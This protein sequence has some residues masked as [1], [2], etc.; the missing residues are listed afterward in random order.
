MERALGRGLFDEFAEQIANPLGM[1]DF[2]PQRQRYARQPYSEQHSTYSFRISTRD[3]A[4]FG[5]LYLSAGDWRGRRLLPAGWVAGSTAVQTITSEG[6]GYGY[7]WWVAHH[8]QLFAG[9]TMP[10]GAFAAYGMSGQFLIVIPELE[11]VV[12]LLADPKRQ[13]QTPKHAA[14]HRRQLANVVHHATEG[15]VPLSTA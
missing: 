4:R 12:A 8:G 11:R 15:S 5:Q 6:P 14:S 13:N 7:L 1:R 9:T 10:D 2:D 3:R